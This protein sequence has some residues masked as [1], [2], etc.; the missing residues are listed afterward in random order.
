MTTR[1]NAALDKA[2]IG[3]MSPIGFGTI[4]KAWRGSKGLDYIVVGIDTAT[5]TIH[6]IK[7]N[8][9]NQDGTVHAAVRRHNRSFS[10][11]LTPSGTC[12]IV[13]GVTSILGQKNNLDPNVIDTFNKSVNPAVTVTGF[14][15]VSIYTQSLVDRRKSA[16]YN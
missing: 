4:L 11:G 6:A 13:Q 8:A 16:V 10:Y 7:H 3:A 2:L 15:R 12:A 5:K 14:N 9:I 1:Q